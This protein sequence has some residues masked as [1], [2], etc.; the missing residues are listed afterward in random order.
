MTRYRLKKEHS[1]KLC[2][3]GGAKNV[4]A[5]SVFSLVK[6]RIQKNVLCIICFIMTVFLFPMA[7]S[8]QSLSAKWYHT[9]SQT[10]TY[11]ELTT[12]GASAADW[13]YKIP[14]RY[15]SI[16]PKDLDPT[17]K[18]EIT[19][20]LPTGLQFR[21]NNA[22]T[23]PEQNDEV[24]AASFTP[25]GTYNGYN[26][27]LTG[28]VKFIT[29]YGTK[30][31]SLYAMTMFDIGVWNKN[32]NTSLTASG[33]AP[34]TVTMK[35]VG[36]STIISQ[37]KISSV[38]SSVDRGVLVPSNLY[39]DIR[40]DVFYVNDNSYT[41]AQ[42]FA[43]DSSLQIA[44]RD[45][46]QEVDCYYKT[47]EVEIYI[48]KQGNSN[49]KA[50]YVN[51]YIATASSVLNN[52]A[53]YTFQNYY[54]KT[55][56]T[57][58][59]RPVYRFPQ[60]ANWAAGDK[61]VVH[62]KLTGTTHT[63]QTNVIYNNDYKTFDVLDSGFTFDS[64][65]RLQG[66]S[67]SG[68]DASYYAGTDRV[69]NF[70]D[71]A[72]SNTAAVSAGEINVKAEFDTE[73]TRYLSVYSFLAPMPAGM[74]ISNGKITLINSSGTTR[75][76]NNYNSVNSTYTP[77]GIYLNANE[78]AAAN[79]V[80]GTWFFK[81]VEYKI[82][83]IPA[84]SNL[85]CYLCSFQPYSGGSFWGRISGGT[86]KSKMTLTYTSTGETKYIT[87]N[88]S[89][90][91]TNITNSLFVRSANA[92][93]YVMAGSSFNMDFVL[94]QAGYPYG[95][96]SYTKNPV[97]YIL[98]PK[99]ISITE[100]KYSDPANSSLSVSSSHAIYKTTTLSGS[101]YNIWKITFGSNAGFGLYK[102]KVDNVYK[103]GIDYHTDAKRNLSL[104]L[105]VSENVSSTSLLLRTLVFVANDGQHSNFQGSYSKW[106]ANDLYDLD[107]DGSTTDKFASLSS[108]DNTTVNVLD[109]V[110]SNYTT[111]QTVNI[112]WKNDDNYTK[113]RTNIDIQLKANGNVIKSKSVS[114]SDNWHYVFSNLPMYDENGLV[115]YSVVE[116]S[117]PVRYSV[118]SNVP[119]PGTTNFTHTMK[120]VDV[121]VSKLWNDDSD[122]DAFRPGSICIFLLDDGNYT[123]FQKELVGN[124]DDWSY[125]FTDIP[126]S[127]DYSVLETGVKCPEP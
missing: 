5:G 79:G 95:S 107:N 59:I 70:G 65:I 4:L 88:S 127:L 106:S 69:F 108:S 36:N 96:T 122:R 6:I 61:A 81:Q 14:H 64:S 27:P 63:G 43:E 112:F 73:N 123:D 34:I 86:A 3:C 117:A 42:S 57:M 39:V 11:T 20:S 56:K 16:N 12:T 76:I 84:S 46:N 45:N 85:Y 35:E 24:S 54:F 111:S 101:P 118:S 98:L 102:N 72:L 2:G 31:P 109:K 124:T 29:S 100:V 93:A 58:I 115:S 52:V 80:T 38:K 8:A 92:P 18:Y 119:T 55:S 90:L 87:A 74:S 25:L 22:W 51:D 21:E 41:A 48:Y 17:K 40:N 37:L 114:A 71:F 66:Y 89:P 13:D 68:A 60:S 75:V 120:L 26:N 104:K 15:L 32:A 116:A 1:D 62:I 9:G 105:S 10:G 99:D 91:T 82:P 125:T 44:F 33:A 97:F 7:A 67:R 83:S 78:V 30:K 50:T 94:E 47:F 23:T 110:T 113:F 53:S 121:Q 126:Y 77:A 103:Y 28:T 19:V 49:I